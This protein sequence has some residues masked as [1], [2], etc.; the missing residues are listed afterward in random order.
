MPEA[1]GWSCP[2]PLRDHPVVVTGHGGGGALSAE[3]MTHLFAPAYG[4]ALLPG[5]ADSAVL[6]VP[7]GPRLAFSTDSY[8]VRPL[9]FPGGSIGDLA[10]NGTV[11]D[12]AMSG[13]RPLALSCGFILEEGTALRT[14][15]RVARAVGAA[16]SAA[17]VT[18]ATGDTKVV[19]AGHGDG[20][21]LSTAGI[22]LVP[23]GVDIRPERAAP[24]DVVLV[25][26]P[27]GA[28]G[29]AILSVREGLEFGAEVRSDTAPLAGLVRAMLD[30][31]PE[32][33]ALRDPTRGG[34]AASLNEIAAASGTGV[35]LAERAVPVPD[36]VTAACGFLG[37]DPLYVAN[38]GRLVAFVPRRHAEAVL[39]AMRAHP[40][41]AGAAVIGECTEEH[42]GMVVARTGLG[43]TRVVDLPIGEQLPRIC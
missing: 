31:T 43:G 16:A 24:G 29:V 9:F 30:V 23:E 33:H 28:H 3:L 21:Y 13:A 41:G 5:L 22:G 27:V 10:V 14:V 25:S 2:A 19:E 42:P 8:V 15:D 39:A 37:L 7:G 36:A 40:Q 32:L 11:N 35:V 4:E 17:G 38:E 20:V 12:L 34:L 18:I 1:E 26:G 6:T